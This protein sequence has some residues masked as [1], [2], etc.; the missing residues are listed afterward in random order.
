MQKKHSFRSSHSFLLAAFLFFSAVV[1]PTSFATEPLVDPQPIAVPK[2]MSMADV[3]KA[4]RV[5][6]SRRNWIVT[7]E[8][9]GKLEL[10]LNVRKHVAKVEVAYDTQKI[11]IRYLDSTNLDYRI[12][13]GVPH[14]HDK[15]LGWVNK[16][17]SGDISRELIAD[18]AQ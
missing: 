3:R 8:E 7:R 6:G 18:S 4:I 16:N 17:L 12:K 11:Q 10:T 14:I 5:G 9:P 1:S 15:Y 13:K 2:G